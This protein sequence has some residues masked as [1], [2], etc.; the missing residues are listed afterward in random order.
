MASGAS[1]FG[2]NTV[3]QIFINRTYIGGCDELFALDVRRELEKLLGRTPP[4]GGGF[5]PD[6]P[7][8]TCR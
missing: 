4:E 2:R 7:R 8:T 1:D 5:G 3:P 6:S